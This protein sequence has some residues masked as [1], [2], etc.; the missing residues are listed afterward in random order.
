MR[1]MSA[2]IT[3]AFAVAA[4]LSAQFEG[5]VTYKMTNPQMGDIAAKY[6]MK[7]HQMAMIMTMP[8]TAGMM[9]GQEVRVVIEPDAGKATMLMP[10]AMG[11]APGMKM[12]MDI[13]KDAVAAANDL[14]PTI[15]KLGTTQTIAGMSCDDYDII[16]AG[17]APGELIALGPAEEGRTRPL[18]VV[19]ARDGAVTRLLL[20]DKAYDFAGRLYRHPVTREVIGAQ[21]ER[22]GPQS[23]W[24]TDDYRDSATTKRAPRMSPGLVPAMFSAVSVPPCASTICRLIDRPRPEFWPKASLDGR[25]V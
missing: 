17:N 23:T 14:K 3:L 21:Y 1:R 20:Q 16:A 19:T 5:T 22:A 18:V 9:A 4:P 7:G 15:K 8:S 12:T 24:F 6:V 11:G 2:V 13:P 10:V 25:S